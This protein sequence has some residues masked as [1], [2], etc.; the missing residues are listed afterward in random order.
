MKNVSRRSFLR[1]SLVGVSG[2][3]IVSSAG[4]V[5]TGCSGDDNDAPKLPASFNHG[6]A[7]GDPLTD[8]VVIWTR[9]TPEDDQAT[10]VYVEWEVAT[11]AD[12]TDVIV[13][14]F[15]RARASSDFTQKIDIVGLESGTEYFYR[16]HTVNASSDIG[17]MKTLP[18]GSIDQV[19]FAVVSCANYPAGYF[20]VYGHAATLENIDA[21]IHLGD[22]LYEYPREGYASEDAENLDRQVLPEGELL[23]LDDYRARYAQYRTDVDLQAFHRA[24]AMIAVWDDHEVANDTWREGAENHDES[25][26]DFIVRLAAALQAYA[27]WMP[28]RPAVDTDVSSLYRNFQF[29]DLVNLIMMDTRL[30]ARDKQLVITDYF[31][32]DGSFNFTSYSSAVNSETRTLIGAEQLDWVVDQMQNTATWKVLGQQVLM[33][34][35]EL[36][37]AVATAQLSTTEY[38]N[39]AQIAYFAQVSPEVLSAEDLAL[40]EQKGSLLALP[41]L[42]YN[43]DAWDG[44]AY[45][46]TQILET[47]YLNNTNL[48]VLAGDTH[49]AWASN[50]T[51]DISSESSQSVGVEFATSSVSSPGLEYYLGL[52]SDEAVA[53]TEGGLVQLISDLQYTNLADRG[54]LTVTFT[55]DN[56][57]A[58]W[59]FV[60]TIKNSSYDILTNRAKSI[61]VATGEHTIT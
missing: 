35:M 40:L 43:L 49:N 13:S 29:G 57:N 12:F 7:S 38:A 6:I 53:Q 27:E 22:Y 45:E 8:R 41:N 42:P 15:G 4:G 19:K 10:D 36:P 51:Y 18:S 26:G 47:A 2:T 56:V 58:E 55:P 14:D 37:G 25:E 33:G 3:I 54:C 16:F 21:A 34:K 61:V 24:F 52:T 28:I 23:T 50:L 31:N 20:H 46:R 60:N 48:V 5:L 11:D 17:K 44:Y 32:T 9:V 59:H 30:V 39:L 1:R